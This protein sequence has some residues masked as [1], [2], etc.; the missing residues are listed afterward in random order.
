MRPN[1]AELPQEL[2]DNAGGLQRLTDAL[3]KGTVS[4]LMKLPQAREIRNTVLA[5]FGIP[6]VVLEH[7]AIRPQF[8]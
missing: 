4:M 8:D 5:D 3:P 7:M 1:A 2:F 6:P